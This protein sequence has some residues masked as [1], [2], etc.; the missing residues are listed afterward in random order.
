MPIKEYNQLERDKIDYYLRTN[1]I[2]LDKGVKI[3]TSDQ[4]VR[5]F[6]VGGPLH[7]EV[8]LTRVN[9]GRKRSCSLEGSEDKIN[10]LEKL[11]GI[12]N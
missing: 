10:E 1:E 4:S 2:H 6:Q 8:I 5:E 11:S 9:I 12:K 3:E 7:Y